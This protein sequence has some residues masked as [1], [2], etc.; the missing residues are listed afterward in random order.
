M[1]DLGKKIKETRLKKSLSQEDLA[2]I[3]NV[4]LRTIQRIENGE[5]IPREKTKKLIFEALDIVE[6]TQSNPKVINK[7]LLFSSFLSV[8]V[9][10]STFLG[11]FKS[12]KFYLDGEKI[13]RIRIG[14]EGYIYLFGDRYQTW[15]LS[16]ASLSVC[17][18]VV[19][20]AL[21]L[22]ERKRKYILV[23]LII[24]IFF[25]SSLFDDCFFRSYYYQPG[26][27]ILT[28]STILLLY[29]YKNMGIV[30][31]PPKPKTKKRRFLFFNKKGTTK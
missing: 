15:I 18:I 27:V 5:T 19:G 26:F 9:F 16:L 17:I 30:L 13:Y 2:E 28:I 20:N 14:W 10:I 11:W 7:Y 31:N 23:Q 22:I 8:L 12:F 24:L 3:S 6:F 1:S 4:N 21:N 25:N 29:L